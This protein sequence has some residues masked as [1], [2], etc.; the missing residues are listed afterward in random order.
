MFEVIYG[1]MHIM[2]G[3]QIRKWTRER[4]YGVGALFQ[5]FSS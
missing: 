4:V 1:H 5:R 3:L 2:P